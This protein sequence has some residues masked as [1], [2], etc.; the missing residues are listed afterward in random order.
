MLA[1]SYDVPGL[2][3]SSPPVI[4]DI[5]ANIGAFTV[6]AS[7]RWP[8]SQILAFEPHPDHVALLKMNAEGTPEDQPVDV[9]IFEGAVVG[10]DGP[11]IMLF[12]GG[13]NHGCASVYQLGEQRQTGHLVD[14]ILARELPPAHVLKLDTEGCEREILDHYQHL[15]GVMVA[16]LE[17]HRLDDYRHFLQWFPL[18]G[19]RLV[20]DSSGGKPAKDRNL[21]FVRNNQT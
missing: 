15:D 5:G 3:F 8:G 11:R 4:L 20:R 13:P 12:D 17:W 19:F 7:A 21:I 10:E 18:H 9:T 16:M 6:W 1:G 2:E 14:R